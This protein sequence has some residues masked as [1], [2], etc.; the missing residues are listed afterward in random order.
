MYILIWIRIFGKSRFHSATSALLM[1]SLYLYFYFRILHMHH[2]AASDCCVCHANQSLHPARLCLTPW[3]CKTNKLQQLCARTWRNGNNCLRTITDSRWLVNVA[4]GQETEIL[5]TLQAIDQSTAQSQALKQ[6]L[7]DRESDLTARVQ[8]IAHYDFESRTQQA[9][10]P[11]AFFDRAR[12]TKAD[13]TAHTDGVGSVVLW[14]DTHS[15]Q[16]TSTRL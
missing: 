4:W 15:N 10:Y 16:N 8:Q 2:V 14:N 12:E 9:R 6:Q 11:H 5:I 3:T 1:Y 13:K 7:N